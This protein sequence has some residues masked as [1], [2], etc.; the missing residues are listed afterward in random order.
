MHK[1]YET[2][3]ACTRRPSAPQIVAYL[4]FAF[5]VATFYAIVENKLVSE[6]ARI[7]LHVFFALSSLLEVVT[8]LIVSLTDPSDEFMIR[9]KNNSLL[10]IY[11]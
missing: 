10:Y 9:Y 5:Q 1:K 8:S 11:D 4:L 6:D 3:N 2:I 7:I